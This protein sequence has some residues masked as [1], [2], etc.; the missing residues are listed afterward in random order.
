MRAPQETLFRKPVREAVTNTAKK[1]IALTIKIP[2]DTSKHPSLGTV[3]AGFFGNLARLTFVL[4][5]FVE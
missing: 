1:E 3:T 2:C 5:S 4:T